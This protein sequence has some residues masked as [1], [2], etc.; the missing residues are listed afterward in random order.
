MIESRPALLVIPTPRPAVD[1]NVSRP[2]PVVGR[3]VE[4]GAHA[5]WP[6]WTITCP[7]KIAAVVA[8]ITWHRRPWWQ[9]W[10]PRPPLELPPCPGA[11]TRCPLPV[12][13]TGAVSCAAVAG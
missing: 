8:S 12:A 13:L 2:I 3:L 6:E 7:T 5:G 4:V 10:G 1:R 9:R 11:A